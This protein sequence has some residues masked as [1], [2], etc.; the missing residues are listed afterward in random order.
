[1]ASTAMNKILNFLGIDK[2]ESKFTVEITGDDGTVYQTDELGVGSAVYQIN[3]DGTTEGVSGITINTADATI[4]VDGNGEI[5]NITEIGQGD[6]NPDGTSSDN[7][8]NTNS[9]TMAKEDK[10]TKIPAVETQA[11][12]ATAPTDDSCPVWVT[13]LISKLDQILTAVSGDTSAPADDTSSED[14]DSE[15]MDTEMAKQKA[16]VAKPKPADIFFKKEAT[17][18]IK[19]PG[20]KSLSNYAFNEQKDNKLTGHKDKG[21]FIR[22]NL[23]EM[24]A[25]SNV[26]MKGGKDTVS[27]K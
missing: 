1:M 20:G 12:A 27:F 3:P 5:S 26:T 18:N 10:T 9:E 8:D 6:D 21:A 25:L 24:I 7:D 11:D 17:T 22:A 4:E 2:I 14:D 15:S 23:E 13:A 19:L 16:N